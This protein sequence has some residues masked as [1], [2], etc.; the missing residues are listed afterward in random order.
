[1]PGPAAKKI[2]MPKYWGLMV[3]DLL[4]MWDRVM[5]GGDLGPYSITPGGGCLSKG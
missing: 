3:W 2:G 4:T 5:S 1:M